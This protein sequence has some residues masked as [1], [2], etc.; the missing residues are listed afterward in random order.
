MPVHIYRPHL[1]F[2]V[3]GVKEILVTTLEMDSIKAKLEKEKMNPEDAKKMDEEIRANK[4]S[5]GARKMVEAVKA[6]QKRG[7]SKEAI[8]K[9]LAQEKEDY[10]RLFA[11]VNDPRHSPAMLYAMLDQLESV[12]R[13]GKST[14]DASVAVGTI[15]VNSFV[16]PKL[17]MEPV[18]LP[19]SGAPPA[20]R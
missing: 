1:F 8:E 20:R 11:M 15:L 6:A 19:G 5:V 2:T 4:R 14:H 7:L 3:N 18:P 10:P 17:G 12:E 9:E 13:G 16:R